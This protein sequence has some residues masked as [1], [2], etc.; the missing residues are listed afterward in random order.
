M[1]WLT[2]SDAGQRP[3]ATTHDYNAIRRKTIFFFGFCI[4]LK[5][6]CYVL[7][8]RRLYDDTFPSECNR[9]IEAGYLLSK[10]ITQKLTANRLVNTMSLSTHYIHIWHICT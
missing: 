8:G 4:T 5:N 6:K 10:V 1:F 2:V 3:E 7:T 9:H